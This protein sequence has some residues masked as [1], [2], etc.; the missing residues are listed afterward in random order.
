MKGCKYCTYT[1]LR[2]IGQSDASANGRQIVGEVGQIALRWDSMYASHEWE[3][4][5]CVFLYLP[6]NWFVVFDT[7]VPR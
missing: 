1:G 3:N 5:E 7:S 2:F 6:S 4:R